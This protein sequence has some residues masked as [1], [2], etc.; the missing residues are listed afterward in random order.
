MHKYKPSRL[1]PDPSELPE[2]GQLIP[3]YLTD[4][5]QHQLFLNNTALYNGRQINVSK[6]EPTASNFKIGPDY[7]PEQ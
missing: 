4:D 6:T 1:A 5:K 2:P 7:V 3:Y